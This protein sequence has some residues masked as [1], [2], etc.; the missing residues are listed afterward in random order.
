MNSTVIPIAAA[1][2]L[3]DCNAL[4]DFVVEVDVLFRARC[5]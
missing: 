1:S 4:L 3:V 2:T 5:L